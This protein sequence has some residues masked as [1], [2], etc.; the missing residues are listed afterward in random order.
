MLSKIINWRYSFRQN[1]RDRACKKDYGIAFPGIMKKRTLRGRRMDTGLLGRQ[2]VR[3]CAAR[4]EYRHGAPWKDDGDCIPSRD[5]GE[6][7]TSKYDI[8]GTPRQDV[9]D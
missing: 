7:D 8:E 1:Y 5:D 4:P 3:Y 9:S 6:H 2:D